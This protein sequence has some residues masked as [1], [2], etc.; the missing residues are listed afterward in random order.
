[1]G[2]GDGHSLERAVVI[3]AEKKGGKIVANL[4]PT[5]SLWFNLSSGSI[6]G[7]ILVFRLFETRWILGVLLDQRLNSS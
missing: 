3:Y 7:R 1:M 5:G 4:L 2:P 6:R